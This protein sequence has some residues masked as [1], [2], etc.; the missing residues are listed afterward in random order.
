MKAIPFSSCLADKML[1]FVDLKCCSGVERKRIEK[2]LGYFDRFLSRRQFDLQRMDAETVALYLENQAQ[3]GSRTRY[4]RF[5]TMRQFCLFLWES[6]PCSHVPD[7]IPSGRKAHVRH[8]H[9]FSTDETSS[10]LGAASSLGPETS[11]RAQT[12]V[13]LVGLL[14]ATGMRIGEAIGINMKD[15]H[16]DTGLLY[17]RKGK[18]GK[19]R[20]IPLSLSAQ[21]AVRGYIDLRSLSPPADPESPLFAYLRGRRLIYASVARVFQQLLVQTGLR[22]IKGPGPH[23]HDLRHSFAVRRLLRWYQ[24]GEDVN[25]R[26]PWLA[27][28]MGHVNIADTMVYLHATV[29]LLEEV[30]NRFET[31]Y[32]TTIKPIQP[33]GVQ[34]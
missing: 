14:C 16:Q 31:H 21:R 15:F 17:I 9:I 33:T 4:D 24:A 1:R 22:P 28:Y 8:A 20:W 25:A 30:G 12:F 19:S 10:L 6:D 34:Q 32:Q 13:T 7:P 23:L 27:T 2:Q 18:F 26:L 11:L 29:E 5:C 3:V